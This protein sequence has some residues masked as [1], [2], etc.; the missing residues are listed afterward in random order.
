MP[1]EEVIEADFAE[2]GKVVEADDSRPFERLDLEDVM[3]VRLRLTAELG[4]ARIRVREVLALKVGSIVTLDKM[5]GEL[6]DI[7]VNGLPLARGEVVVISDVLH[8]RLSEILTNAESLE[9]ESG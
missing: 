8:V 1:E 7:F 5:A 2:V 3:S 6:T 4:Q 9:R